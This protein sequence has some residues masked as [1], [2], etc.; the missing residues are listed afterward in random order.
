MSRHKSKHTTN[1]T[2]LGCSDIPVA[3]A[4]SDCIIRHSVNQIGTYMKALGRLHLRDSE[5]HDG[6]ASNVQNHL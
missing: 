1:Y 6:R 5:V 2:R 3:H 4:L